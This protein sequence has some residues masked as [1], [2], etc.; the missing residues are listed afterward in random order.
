MR[1]ALAGER[2]LARPHPSGH[3][4]AT[5]ILAA[6]VDRV[7]PACPHAAEC[8]G[9]T[10]QHLAP[11]VTLAAKS[12]RVAQALVEA[13]FPEPA[14]RAPVASAPGTRRRMD[15][16]FAAAPGGLLLGLH[17]R[18]TRRIVDLV[19]C[20]VAA[21][22]IVRLLPPLRAV[23]PSLALA[24]RGRGSVVAN[25][26]E[27]GID[28]LLRSDSP[29]DTRDRTRL[30]AF[31]AAEGVLRVAWQAETPHRRAAPETLAS[32]RPASVRFA[33][34]AVAAPPGA[35]LQATPEGEAAMVGDVRDALAGLARRDR[36]VELYAGLGTLTFPIAATHRVL[37]VEGAPEA[38]AAL[39]RAAGGTRVE[40]LARDLAR[41]P[42]SEA[43]LRGVAALV[44]DPPRNGAGPQMAAIARAAPPRVVM[45][46]CNPDALRRDARILAAAGYRLEGARAIDQFLFSTEIESVS[47]FVKGRARSP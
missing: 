43:E 42:M 4:V 2:V 12:A 44:L 41:A 21:P 30:A 20:Q 6:S 40:V 11:A 47:V 46:S 33:D 26:L 36:V 18:G 28:L 9:C 15:L 39:R 32:L 22:A 1:G 19:T 7:I 23:L 3:H 10:L 35:F 37:A 27:D 34:V 45:V 13:G 38:V 29:P 8:G 25:L 31:A 5:A 24:A 16:A 17:E 14:M